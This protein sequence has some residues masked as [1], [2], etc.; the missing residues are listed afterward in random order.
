MHFMSLTS[1][2]PFSTERC[3]SPWC[4]RTGRQPT[5]SWRGRATRGSSYLGTR[6]RGSR[7]VY[8]VQCAQMLRNCH[9][10]E[11]RR[12]VQDVLLPT[13]PPCG[14]LYVDHVVGN[15]PDLT[16][17]SAAKWYVHH[18][19]GVLQPHAELFPSNQNTTNRGSS[20]LTLMPLAMITFGAMG[21]NY[22]RSHRS[23]GGRNLNLLAAMRK[24]YTFL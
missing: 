16:M 1:L 11:S 23:S 4:R 6:S 9:V 2:H 10:A 8:R 14:V 22:L 17:E 21:W 19:H 5:P 12:A 20:T 24:E 15:Q 18:V 7:Y 3:V 13:L